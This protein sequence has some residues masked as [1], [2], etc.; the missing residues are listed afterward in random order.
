MTETPHSKTDGGRVPPQDLDAEKSLLG[1]LMLSDGALADV[2]T[3]IKPADFYDERH[4]F[5]FQA[6]IDLY[7][8]HQPVDLLTLTNELRA[9]KKLRG[10]GGAPYLTELSNF[11]PAASHARS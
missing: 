4:Q 10:V 11:T 9:Q 7:D 8:K 1:A 3:V 5:I 6:M 2:L